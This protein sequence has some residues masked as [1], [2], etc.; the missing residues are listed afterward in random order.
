VRAAVIRDSAPGLCYDVDT[1]REYEY[2]CA[3][4]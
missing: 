2:A 3:R 1:L 4:R